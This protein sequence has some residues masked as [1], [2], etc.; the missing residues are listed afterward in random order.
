[1]IVELIA[2]TALVRPE[3]VSRDHHREPIVH[4]WDA[5]AE[6][7]STGDWHINTGNGY[8][9]GVQ[10]DMS[11]WMNYGGLRF[12]PRPDLATRRQQIVVAERGLAAQGI[13]AWPACGWHLYEEAA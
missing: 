13:G 6:C 11:F 4:N 8:Y 5:V 7:E 2:V 10:M 9:G 1:M 3:H 12:A